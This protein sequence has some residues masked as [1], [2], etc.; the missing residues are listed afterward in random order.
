MDRSDHPMIGSTRRPWL[1]GL[2]IAAIVALFL[3]P[4]ADGAA[5]LS[6]YEVRQCDAEH[7]VT[8]RSGLSST[9][10]PRTAFW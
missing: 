7:G 2:L 1:G 3:W 6:I 4:L 5:A 9:R 8:D 10:R